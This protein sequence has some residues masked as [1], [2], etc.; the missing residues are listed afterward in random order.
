MAMDKKDRVLEIGYAGLLRK[1][2]T[3]EGAGNALV[4]DSVS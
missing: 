1:W 4:L 2:S 3:V